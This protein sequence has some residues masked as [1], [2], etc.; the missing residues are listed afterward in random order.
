MI[1]L[2]KRHQEQASMCKVC[3]KTKGSKQNSKKLN[4]WNTWIK[5]NQIKPS[6]HNMEN[7]T[8]VS[9]TVTGDNSEN[10]ISTL[11]SRN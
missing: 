10:Q 9:C 2:N 11:M 5:S 3:Y 1:K 4:H 7:E 8:W 6:I